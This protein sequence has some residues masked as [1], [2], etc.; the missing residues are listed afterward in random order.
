MD[1]YFEADSFGA[2]FSFPWGAVGG[3]IKDC[4][5]AQIKILICVLAG[6]SFTDS[7]VIS[8]MSGYG[9]AEV[10]AAVE[11]WC[12]LGVLHIRGRQS[13]QG[14]PAAAPIAEKTHT[15]T[16]KNEPVSLVEAVRPAV[17]TSVDRKVTVRYSQREMHEKAE[18]DS[19]L[20]Y[21]VNE[22]Q[23]LQFSINGSEFA[24]LIELYEYYK[25]DV[26][27]ILLVADYCRQSGKSNISYLYTVLTDWFSKDIN[28]YSE[29]EQAIIHAGESRA[30]ENKI[31]KLFGME[32]KPS[33][34][35]HA[36]IEEWEKQGFNTDLIG[37]AYDKCLDAK[38]KLSF[39][40]INGIL[41]KWAEKGISTVE[42]SGEDDIRFRNQQAVKRETEKPSF[43]LDEYENYANNI[44]LS[45]IN[46]GSRKGD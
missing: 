17:T 34:K 21:L 25:F 1:Y 5:E 22:I 41:K 20:K 42:Q 27:S 6:A 10:D 13:G 33:K 8:A 4:T 39:N 32:N 37:I 31:Q 29:V 2:S 7:A 14:E 28:T 26:P 19:N 15:F 9:E 11:Y 24:K 12:S 18:Q 16:G 30:F 3:H 23:T 43:N 36:F 40:Y 45:T 38:G 46:L 35:Q 44:D